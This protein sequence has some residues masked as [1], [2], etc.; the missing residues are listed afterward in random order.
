MIPLFSF[1]LH[2]LQ[3]GF[4]VNKKGPPK[5]AKSSPK[6]LEKIS[7]FCVKKL[8]FRCKKY[9][10][11]WCP[12]STPKHPKRGHFWRQKVTL[13]DVKTPPKSTNKHRKKYPF[14]VSKSCLFDAKSTLNN[15]CKYLMRSH[16]WRQKVTLI[17]VKT[18]TK[19]RKKHP[20]TSKKVPIF[21]VEKLP[22]QCKKYP[23]Q[24]PK[25]P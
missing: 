16:F 15:V 8:P 4:L 2:C 7:I 5:R 25:V 14:F 1:H 24:R 3:M 6:P 13:I 19:R 12:K 11:R 17:D 10:K 9:L 20:Q 21:C 18:P 22:F 23:K